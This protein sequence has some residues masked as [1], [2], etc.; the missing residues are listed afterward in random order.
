MSGYIGSTP[1]PQAT[2]HRESFTATAGQTSFA[3][4]GYT[5]QFVDVYLNG[6]HLSP[7]DVTATNGSDVVLAACLVNDI[8][9]V[10]SY[11]AFEV[12]AQT[13]T[14]TTT[15]TGDLLLGDNDKAIFGAG[16]DLQIYHDGSNSYIKDVGTGDLT[17][18]GTNLQIRSSST[19]ENFIYCVE[20]GAVNLYHND[21]QKMATSA[22]G[23]DVTGTA[24]ATAD[25]KAH[26]SSSGD[27]VRMYGGSGTG[28]WDI[29][30]NGAN[31]RIG[32]NES[33]GSVQFDT[34]VGIGTSSPAR[35]LSVKGADA[36]GD[37]QILNSASGV[38]ATDGLL[39]QL[40]GTTSYIWNYEAGDMIL[41]TNNAERM[42]LDASGNLLV[43]TTN[44]S[45]HASGGYGIAIRPSAGVLIG[46]NNTHAIIAARWNGN[47]EVIR[48]QR[49]GS[50]VGSI[51]VTTSSTSYNTSSDY[52]LKT[53]AQSMTGASARVQALNPVNFEWIA[54]GDR[55]DGFLAH[56]A[57][58]V[59]PEAV[60]G[61]KDAMRDEEYEVT[62]A[63]EATYDDD[64]NELTAAVEAVMGTRSVPD[65]QGI[66]QS[67]LVPLLTAALQEALTEIAS[68]K[69]RV[70]ALEDV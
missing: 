11:S 9:D 56:E 26:S 38:A 10:I 41:A 30:G 6:V 60:T 52:R 44:V 67:K 14:G 68:L 1:V 70:E 25:F 42:R 22:T 34:K 51:D 17:I 64:G 57:A 69:T 33:A 24:T 39:M 5:A 63:I 62:A 8:V 15:L 59:V 20:N 46:V 47:G 65:M 55:V 29:Y 18:A 27:Y 50:D 7:A 53:D 32:D 31:L 21:N 23:I 45:P 49:D 54:S 2:Q 12:N 37:I 40:N 3:T 36:A 28:K 61:T 4:A 19:N 16:S 66:D 58:T 13:F 48:L 35:G 43:G